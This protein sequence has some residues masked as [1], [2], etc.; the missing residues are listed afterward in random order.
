[1]K[2]KLATYP[3]WRRLRRRRFTAM[4]VAEET[5][6]GAVTLL[7][8]D[9]VS[10]PSWMRFAAYHV[11]VAD[12]GYSVV[13]HFPTGALHAI[14]A[15]LDAEDRIIHWYIDI[16]KA[17]GVDDAGI[18]WYDDLYLDIVV[19]PDGTRHILDADEFDEAL[20]AGA[21]TSEDWSLAW[22]ETERLLAALATGPL[23]AMTRCHA[24]LARLRAQPMTTFVRE[25]G[26]D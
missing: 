3:D 14:T 10:P 15:N 26:D 19:R 12:H 22:A 16:C 1:M 4:N 21:I 2:H 20:A 17:H 6:T 24:D 18:P 13:Q 8:M 9:E 5:F 23:P 11:C 7:S 25:P